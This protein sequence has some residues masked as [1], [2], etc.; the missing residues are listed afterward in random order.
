MIRPNT[1]LYRVMDYELQTLIYTGKTGEAYYLVSEE[2]RE[3]IRC[4]KQTFDGL[5][6]SKITV[7]AELEERLRLKLDKVHDQMRKHK[8]QFN[9]IDTPDVIYVLKPELIS[10]NIGSSKEAHQYHPTTGLYITT[11][12]ST[13]QAAKALTGTDKFSNISRAI[14]LNQKAFGYYWSYQKHLKL[15]L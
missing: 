14:R 6:L 13:R 15:K 8:I 9:P 12:Q 2:S 3:V 5:S 1:K 10:K 4:H 7:L 11:F